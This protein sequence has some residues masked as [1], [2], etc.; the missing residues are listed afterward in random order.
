MHYAL[1]LCVPAHNEAP[2][3][4]DTVRVLSDVLTQSTIPSWRIIVADNGSTAGTG[5]AVEDARVPHVEVLHIGASGKGRALRAAARR[6]DA[7]VFGFIDADLSAAPEHIAEFYAQVRGGADLVVGS[8]L[9]AGSKVDRGLMRTLSS[10]LF[11]AA[12]RTLLDVDVRDAQC[13]LKLMNGSARSLLAACEEDTWFVDVELLARARRNGLTV[14]EVPIAWEE[15]RYE[16]R[17][18][19]LRPLADGAAALRAMAAIRQRISA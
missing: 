16:A 17:H 1:D 3:I 11:N 8:R 4:L 13:G 6:S 10:R 7:D 14:R 18:S 9:L 5:K 2:I 19:K 15:Y 12:A